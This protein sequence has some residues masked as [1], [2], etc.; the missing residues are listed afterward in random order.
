[1]GLGLMV[2][3]GLALLVEWFCWRFSAGMRKQFDMA[4]VMQGWMRFSSAVLRILPNL[5]GIVIF[6]VMS[7]LLYA[8]LPVSQKWGW[9]PLF[10]ATML[11]IVLIRLIILLSR[12]IFSPKVPS[13][14]LVALWTQRP[15]NCTGLSACFSVLPP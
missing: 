4:P 15:P 12:L 7:G 1:M 10:I 5:L 13:L 14:R 11:L 9:R 6:T 3:I 2:I 8:V